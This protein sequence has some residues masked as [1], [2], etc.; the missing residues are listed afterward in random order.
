MSEK[1]FGEIQL[2]FGYD[3]V[4]ICLRI[5]NKSDEMHLNS[6][7]NRIWNCFRTFPMSCNWNLA[8]TTIEII[9]EELR[10]DANEFG[11]RQSSEVS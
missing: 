8:K 11:L 3:T 5:N 6:G 1:I 10:W 4:W 2:N 7:W 9:L